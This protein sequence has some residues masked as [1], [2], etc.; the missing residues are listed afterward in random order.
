MKTVILAEKPPQAKAYAEAFE[1]AKREKTH[2]ELKPCSIF[3]HGAVITWGIG[4]LVEIAL[5]GEHDEKWANWNLEHLPVIPKQFNLKVADSKKVQFNAVSKLLKEA[6]LIING[7]DIDREGSNIFYLILKVAGV[8]NKPIK[9]LFINS[10]EIDAIRKGFQNL[11]SNEKDIE[12]DRLMHQEAHAR[13]IADWLVGM[14]GS[15]LYSLLL[16]KQGLREKLSVGRCQ[17]PLVMMIYDHEQKIKNFIAKPF[18]E[19][20]GKF[21]TSGRLEYVGKAKLKLDSKEELN[22]FLLENQLSQNVSM[23]GKITNVE[24][25]TKGTKAPRLHSLSTLQ[26]TANKKWKYSPKTVLDTMQTLYEAKLVTYPR[27][28]CNFITEAEFAYLV[29]NVEKYQQIINVSFE[30]NTVLNKLYVDNSKVQE[31]F[32]IVP[33]KTIP[34]INTL[35]G[36]SE[37]ERNIYEE[38][39]RTTLAMFHSDYKYEET[40]ITTSVNDVEFY[41]KGKVELDLGWKALFVKDSANEGEDKASVDH[42]VL[43]A[44]ST[45]E[46]VRALLYEKEGSTTPPKPFTEGQLIGLMKTAGKTLDIDEGDAEILKEVEGI[47]TDATRSNIIETVKQKEY[48]SIK[49]NIVSVTPKGE[50]LCKALANSLVGSPILTAKWESKLRLIGQGQLTLESFVAD[51]NQYILEMI[52]DAKKNITSNEDLNT[53]ISSAQTKSEIGKCPKCNGGIVEKKGFFGC[54]NYP[55]CKF[56]LSDNFR[57]KKLTKANIKNLLVG[58]ETTIKGIKKADT[59]TYNAVVKLNVKGFLDFVSFVK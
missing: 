29:Q 32:A 17:S 27:T 18:Y 45:N 36:L 26:A 33:T 51:I 30:A 58:K 11:Q 23:N 15:P 5:P 43:P 24:K 6:D 31:H 41:T 50:I 8:V 7:C 44:V 46:D 10:L 48:I 4:H 16:Q 53:T 42:T 3:P 13:Q 56:T 54:S 52:Q 25:E 40:V 22:N 38:I 28:S 59:S 35:N 14:N 34:A 55:N 49:K 37:T 2:I 12:K 9:R 19:L 21:A 39:L 20:H 1:I 57:K 47:G